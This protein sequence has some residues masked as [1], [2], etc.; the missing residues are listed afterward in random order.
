MGPGAP[1]LAERLAERVSLWSRRRKFELFME[2][3]RPDQA[4]RIVDV[5]VADTGFGEARGLAHTHN[6]FEAMYPWP[7]RITAVGLGA[8]AGFQGAFPSVETVTA[9]GTELPFPDGSFDIAFSNAVIE[10]VGGR[11]EQRAFV[12][13][14]CR[15]A[16]R[17]F[18]T[19]PNRLFPVDSHTLLPVF[20]WLP[21]SARNPIYSALRRD[22]GVGVE[23]LT[24]R[25]LRALFPR[26]VRIVNS[27]FTLVAVSESVALGEPPSSGE[28]CGN[29]P[30]SPS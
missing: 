19:T 18:L 22:D 20:H 15:V 6:F 4:T 11:D 28:E 21:A 25:G 26:P 9:D 17:V 30:A 23:L 5:G 29:N 13:E 3:M 27:G 12:R 7:H 1:S 2:T 24:P 14:L 8:L 10:H 16:P